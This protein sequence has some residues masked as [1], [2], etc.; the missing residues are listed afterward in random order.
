M[1]STNGGA[2]GDSSIIQELRRMED[3]LNH[4]IDRVV[5]RVDALE[6]T[7]APPAKRTATETRHTPSTLW[8]DRGVDEPLPLRPLDDWPPSD[9][10]ESESA[11]GSG[12]TKDLA[13]VGVKPYSLSDDVAKRVASSFTTVLPNSERKRVR[14]AHPFPDLNE[15]RCPRLDSL[16]SSSK[17]PKETRTMDRELARVQA[18]MHDPVAPLLWMIHSIDTIP[19]DEARAALEDSVHLLGNAS[20]NLSQLRRRRILKSVNPELADLAEED[21]FKTSAPNLFGAGFEQKM[22]ERAESV[23][24]LEVAKPQSLQSRKFFRGG[25][26]TIPQRGGGQANRGGSH[27]PRPGKSAVRK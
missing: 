24:L 7:T 4:S 9:D 17:I 3:A 25:R 26:P 22:K 13:D 8:A 1:E 18:L 12:R 15:T 21:L 23:K 27:W 16:F 5:K 11:G 14:D 10:E 19:V 20:A 6:R 2:T